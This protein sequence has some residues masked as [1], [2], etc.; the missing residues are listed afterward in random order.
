M[1]LAQAVVLVGERSRPRAV[2]HIETLGFCLAKRG[3]EPPKAMIE[4]M[5][6]NTLGLRTRTEYNG[7]A[8]D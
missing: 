2:W 1:V 7:L 3:I 5:D 4:S 8:E 6:N